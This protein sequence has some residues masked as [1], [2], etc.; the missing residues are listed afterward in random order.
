MPFA[1]YVQNLNPTGNQPL[2]TAIAALPVL[3]L[4]YLLVGRR[5]ACGSGGC[6]LLGCRS[7]LRGLGRRSF[8]GLGRGRRRLLGESLRRQRSGRQRHRGEQGNGPSAWQG[9][10]GQETKIHCGKPF[11][12]ASI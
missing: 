8:L 10:R 3:V 7:M 11:L 9:R 1:V 6:R 12:N 2:S 4:F 5:L